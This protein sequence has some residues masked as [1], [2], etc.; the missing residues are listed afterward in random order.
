MNADKRRLVEFSYSP[1]FYFIVFIINHLYKSGAVMK[2]RRAVCRDA[3]PRLY[4]GEGGDAGG[5]EGEYL[6]IHISFNSPHLFIVPKPRETDL[7]IPK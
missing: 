2:S 1:Y 4:N 5:G 6:V 7:P 3:A